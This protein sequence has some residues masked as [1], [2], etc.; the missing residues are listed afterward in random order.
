MTQNIK[1]NHEEVRLIAQTIPT[2]FLRYEDLKIDPEP[3]LT[4][5]FCFLLGVPSIEVTVVQQRVKI[6]SE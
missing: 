5:L 1:S 3:V 2:Y 4:E 6:A